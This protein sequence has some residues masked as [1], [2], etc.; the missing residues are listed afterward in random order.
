[1]PPAPIMAG[2][3]KG[4]AGKG[5]NELLHGD[6]LHSYRRTK[7][8]PIHTVNCWDESYPIISLR[9]S[10][11]RSTSSSEARARRRPI[12]ST[13]R[14]RIWLILTHDRFGRPGALL[15]D[16]SGKPARGS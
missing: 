1:M 15:S 7:A 12:R 6:L 4:D 14:V 5:R 13:E 10:T 3:M 11:T 2:P 8:R 16:V 9:P